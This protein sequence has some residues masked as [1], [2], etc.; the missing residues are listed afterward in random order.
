MSRNE[1]VETYCI[2]C[3]GMGEIWGSTRR[4]MQTSRSKTLIRC[5]RCGG[6]GRVSVCVPS[7]TWAKKSRDVQL[8]ART[9]LRIAKQGH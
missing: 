2:V 7:T 6:T 3:M 5:D 1:W 8:L 9:A 4:D